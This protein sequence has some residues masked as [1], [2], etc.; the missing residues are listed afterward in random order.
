MGR[1]AGSKGS[2][3]RMDAEMEP[4]H[5]SAP[6]SGVVAQAATRPRANSR[7]PP[8]GD[9]RQMRAAVLAAHRQLR[10]HS[11]PSPDQ[12]LRPGTRGRTRPE[13]TPFEPRTPIRWP[14]VE[15]DL[16][17]GRGA[18]HRHR[19]VE[20]RQTM[21]SHA[22]TVVALPA[23]GGLA[24]RRDH[25]RCPGGGPGTKMAGQRTTSWNPSAGI[26]AQNMP[27]HTGTVGGHAVGCP[28]C[29]RR[30]GA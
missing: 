11:G 9:D 1:R 7:C 28:Y 5:G 6:R 17:C 27:I 2:A 19:S 21:T 15:V 29:G 8:D 18:G 4:A 12:H 10:A 14:R 30:S 24:H 3:A 23:D 22:A 13:G 20:A 16:Q 26:E 25:T